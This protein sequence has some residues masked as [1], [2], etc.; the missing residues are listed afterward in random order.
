M[1]NLIWRDTRCLYLTS[2]SWIATICASLTKIYTQMVILSSDDIF[3]AIFVQFTEMRT[4]Q[5]CV[6]SLNKW[7][8]VIRCQSLIFVRTY[9]VRLKASI[10]RMNFFFVHIWLCDK[11]CTAIISLHFHPSYY[12]LV[13]TYPNLFRHINTTV[14]NEQCCD[15]QNCLIDIYEKQLKL[16]FSTNFN[17]SAW[18]LIIFH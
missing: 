15:H 11:H 1:N 8:A 18:A 2:I 12:Q 4:K 10:V 3:Q 13:L 9:I 14:D 6:Y 5:L 16:H 17:A 7:N